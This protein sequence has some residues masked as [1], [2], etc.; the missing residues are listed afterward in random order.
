MMVPEW[1]AQF[2]EILS[3]AS[4]GR[5]FAAEGEK[6]GPRCCCGGECGEPA[7]GVIARAG[8]AGGPS[9]SSVNREFVVEAVLPPTGPEIFEPFA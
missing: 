2:G 4:E 9:G 1:F 5:F 6:G 3:K 7:L 8:G